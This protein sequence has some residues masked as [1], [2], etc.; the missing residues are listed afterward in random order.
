M[1]LSISLELRMPLVKADDSTDSRLPLTDA[2]GSMGR[3][4]CHQARQIS[5]EFC[6][7][8]SSVTHPSLA[9]FTFLMYL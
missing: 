4:I 1:S 9:V 8:Y 2:S 7:G 6:Y 3:G 5:K